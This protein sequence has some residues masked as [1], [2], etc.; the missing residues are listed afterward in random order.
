GWR[1]KGRAGFYFGERFGLLD[2]QL[3]E[4]NEF[5]H[6]QKGDDDFHTAGGGFE[7]FGK[8]K[9][10]TFPDGPGEKIDLLA[11]CPVLFEEIAT[12]VALAMALEDG[13]DGID[14]VKNRNLGPDA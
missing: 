10:G 1:W 13:I 11:Y 6:S 2:A 7:Q 12:L 5:E 3:L 8:S 14:Q 9:A 4:A